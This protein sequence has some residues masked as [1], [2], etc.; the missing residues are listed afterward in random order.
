MTL[1]QTKFLLTV[2]EERSL[3]RAGD[4]LSVPVVEITN[5]LR[6][7]EAELGA[8][9]LE[10][11][12][13]GLRL[14]PA[15]RAYLRAAIV[16]PPVPPVPPVDQ[17]PVVT[18]ERAARSST[19]RSSTGRSSTGQSSTTGPADDEADGRT[20]RRAVLF[21]AGATGLA[22]VGAA[23]F[24]WP[25]HTPRP[26]LGVTAGGTSRRPTQ[27]IG[28]SSSA[29]AQSGSAIIRAENER[30][31]SPAW[32]LAEPDR[33]PRPVE[34]FTD[35]ASARHGQPVRL[36]VHSAS[37]TFSVEAFRLGWYNGDKARLVW[38]T[39]GVDGGAQDR[40]TIDPRTNMVDCSHWTSNLTF[41]PDERWVHGQYLL[42]LVQPDG[43]ASYVPF[44][45]RSPA[46]RSEV[47]VVA[48][49]TT[50][51]AYETWG[52]HSLYAG[53][54]GGRA[55][56]ADVVTL[57]RPFGIG[58]GGAGWL[59]GGSSEI[60]QLLESQGVDVAYATNVD[61]HAE[62][63]VMA[64]TNVVISSA[65]DEYY[66]PEMRL[67]LQAAVDRGVNVIYLGANALYRKIRF[68]RSPIGDLRRIVNYRSARTD[69]ETD[70]NLVTTNW[71]EGPRPQPESMLTGNWYES[72]EPGLTAPFRIVDGSAWMFAGTG[73]ATGS[74]VAAGVREEYDR[75]H[76]DKPLPHDLQILSHSPFT[77]RGERSAS[78]MTYAT[79][80]SGAAIFNS[81]T[82]RF[83]QRMGPL[84]PPG[85]GGDDGAVRRLV[86]N[87]VDVFRRGPAAP[88]HQARRNVE[89]VYPP[90]TTSVAT[91]DPGD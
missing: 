41:T 20:S 80:P 13:A 60:A 48:G 63:A 62:P 61:Q 75:V 78:D 47:L 84:S 24:G 58:Y 35:V 64:Q 39:F 42:K 90:G 51:A 11:T 49:V 7:L 53:L 18:L 88:G 17:P 40:P 43:R 89:Q 1:R 56:R 33:T 77:I 37:P 71:R 36:F 2:A 34:G 12:T 52:G 22:A 72:N 15:G 69:P 32:V 57:D 73:L 5:H 30:P 23:V 59:L 28:S 29:A 55:E 3:D 16:A 46:E 66:S 26:K 81:G 86:W 70:P 68:E 67:G 19:G 65:H 27:L 79:F 74:L 21:G 6:A 14:T 85:Q 44:V 25:T 31:G 91:I 38:S 9:V 87:L 82:L 54:T 83:Q 8:A 45:V 76:P 10:R 4:R 50:A